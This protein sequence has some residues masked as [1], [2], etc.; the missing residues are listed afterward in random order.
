MNA[1]VK[2]LLQKYPH[3]EDFESWML[4]FKD[5]KTLTTY[6]QSRQFL[7]YPLVSREEK[8]DFLVQ[9]LKANETQK[10]VLGLLL[11][12]D[13]LF[14]A[15]QI[16]SLYEKEYKNTASMLEG[17]IY[18]DAPLAPSKIKALE[19]LFEKKLSKKVELKFSEQKDI[20]GIRAV[21]GS[22]CYSLTLD[23]VIHTINS[24]LLRG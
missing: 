10:A 9:A 11:D 16:C 19:E 22:T 2:A 4:F 1:L 20:I 8:F 18:S 7:T 23:D 5:L 6:H 3:K 24:E 12:A 14:S 13:N 15:G 17:E 21:V